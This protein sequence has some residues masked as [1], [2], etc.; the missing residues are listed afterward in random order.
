[1]VFRTLEKA[2]IYANVWKKKSF[3]SKIFEKFVPVVATNTPQ[4]MNPWQCEDFKKKILNTSESKS[5][6][7]YHQ[8]FGP[9]NVSM[10]AVA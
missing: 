5:Y 10:S 9:W 7:L 1:M 2:V 8:F 4:N 3:F 6:N